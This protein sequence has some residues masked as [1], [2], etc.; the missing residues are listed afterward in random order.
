MRCVN[1]LTESQTVS[2]LRTYQCQRRR[3]PKA[4]CPRYVQ[5]RQTD[6]NSV[7]ISSTRAHNPPKSQYT[8]PAYPWP[9]P[10]L[11]NQSLMSR[12]RTRPVSA[13]ECGLSAVRD[14]HRQ[15]PHCVPSLR[16]SG[17]RHLMGA[18]VSGSHHVPRFCQTLVYGSLPG[19]GFRPT[20]DNSL[21]E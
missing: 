10:F 12:T 1:R 17:G 21:L 18:C 11:A 6:S 5:S 14:S 7:S 13:D 9:D 2:V 15:W 8:L 3:K 20:L 16:V 4:S 19:P